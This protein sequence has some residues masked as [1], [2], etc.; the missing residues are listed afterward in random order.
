MMQW[1]RNGCWALALLAAGCSRP[2]APEQ[3][4]KKGERTFEVRG[5]VHGVDAAARSVMVEHEEIP[6]FMPAMTMPFTVRDPRELG[7]IVV[8]EAVAFRFV[9]GERDAWITG[10]R[11][12][13]RE[14]LNL[15]TQ[16]QAEPGER[17]PR[18]REGERVPE[19]RLTDSAGQP[20]TRET[21]A[22]RR[23]LLTFIFTRCPLPNFCPLMSSQ[24]AALQERI[25]A[26]PGMAEKVRLLSISF[27]PE[28]TPQTLARYGAGVG[29]DPAL[30]QHAGGDEAETAKLTQAFSVFVRQEGGTYTHG[31]CTAL[32]A[33]DGTVEALWRGN[34]WS[35]EEV[36]Q[37]LESS[38]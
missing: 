24:F 38:F 25:R 30:W 22:G 28:D 2:S 34:G 16:K 12:I 37:A 20:L 5:L 17:Q 26:T 1:L 31:L 33:P 18:L 19:F 21:L 32:L 27:D 36:W 6:G 14:G 3:A 7:G 9:V 23:T 15:P 8:G 10:L 11:G 35:V 4:D 13:R 29:A